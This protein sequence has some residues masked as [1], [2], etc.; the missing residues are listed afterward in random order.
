MATTSNSQSRELLLSSL[1]QH[2]RRSPEQREQLY[3]IVAGTSPLSLRVIDWFVTHYSRSKNIIYWI[4]D[5]NKALIEDFPSYGGQDL[6][7]FN[8]HLEYHAQ[9]QSYTKMYF[10][11]FRRH[12][13]ITFVL[14]K[15]PM[16]SITS[17]VGQ[18]N[19]F[20]WAL[21]NGVIEYI[22]R[23]LHDIEENMSSFQNAVKNKEKPKKRTVSCKP[24]NTF[25]HMQCF[26]KF[27]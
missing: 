17:T 20:R 11:P 9:L 15:T 12:E 21:Q 1:S 13:K 7:K 24:V 22:T 27:D 4:D 10:D 6:R 23:H 25:T 14:E 8:L 3:T 26:V 2:Y 19:F 16:V 18:L 5:K